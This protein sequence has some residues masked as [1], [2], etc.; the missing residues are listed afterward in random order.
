MCRKNQ[1]YPDRALTSSSSSKVLFNCFLWRTYSITIFVWLRVLDL[2]NIMAVW[3]ALALPSRRKSKNKTYK[4]PTVENFQ[5]DFFKIRVITT[6]ES[7]LF[8][9]SH[10]FYEQLLCIHIK[11]VHR[12]HMF[13]TI[14]CLL[15]S[16]PLLLLFK[17]QIRQNIIHDQKNRS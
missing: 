4:L 2:L 10:H 15:L 5:L 7:L 12:K 16:K 1:V 6:Q 14:S 9:H 13:N 11:Y 3:V 17:S 8:V